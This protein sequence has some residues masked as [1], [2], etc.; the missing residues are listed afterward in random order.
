[1]DLLEVIAERKE[2]D[3]FDGRDEER[4]ERPFYREKAFDEDRSSAM[5]TLL[6]SSVK[7]END[8]G[9]TDVPQR[10]FFDEDRRGEEGLN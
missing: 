2:E 8:L 6:N 4:K 9:R 10:L 3:I 5:H 1:M 7:S